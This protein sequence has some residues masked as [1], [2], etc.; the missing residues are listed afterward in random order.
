MIKTYK[1]RFDM[2]CGVCK[3]VI[4]KG[5]KY[6]LLDDEPVST[7]CMRVTILRW[8]IAACYRDK[9]REAAIMEEYRVEE[10]KV[11][12][13]EEQRSSRFCKSLIPQLEKE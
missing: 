9:K 10:Q 6:N 5:V 7:P 8:D 1:A 2:Q 12:V 4:G 11:L 3:G 13:K